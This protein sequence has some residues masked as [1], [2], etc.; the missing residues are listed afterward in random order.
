MHGKEAYLIGIMDG[1][2]KVLCKR[3]KNKS[4]KTSYQVNGENL[5]KVGRNSVP[6]VQDALNIRDIEILKAK[7]EMNFAK[8]F[9]FPFLL[10]K[11]PSQLYDFL[12]SSDTS[13]DLNDIIKEMKADLKEISDKQKRL[14]G[15]IDMAKSSFDREKVRYNNLVNSDLLINSILMR[16]GEV[17]KLSTNKELF[18]TVDTVS[19]DIVSLETQLTTTLA[20]HQVLQNIEECIRRHDL[21]EQLL[22]SILEIADINKQGVEIKR[23][24]SRLSSV[25]L[26]L[27]SLESQINKHQ[28]KS[29]TQIALGLSIQE[30]ESLESNRNKTYSELQSSISVLENLSNLQPSLEALNDLDNLEELINSLSELTVKVSEI[31]DSLVLVNK[32]LEEVNTDLSEFKFCPF[33]DSTL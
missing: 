3:N 19:Q 15:A 8:Q 24:L 32:E 29:K 25:D 12:A 4:S 28:D 21:N 13:N 7:T 26:D 1:E 31:E 33:C 10:D 16:A 11:T 18:N 14:E 20:Q 17:N 30:L 9:A 5:I 27:V 6:E 23:E 22:S 2:N